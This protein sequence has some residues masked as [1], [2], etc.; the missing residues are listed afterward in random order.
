MVSTPVTT[1]QPSA[2]VKILLNERSQTTHS[3]FI[4]QNIR[5]FLPRL[6][7]LPGRTAPNS[8][9]FPQSEESAGQSFARYRC[10]GRDGASAVEPGIGE[11][12]IKSLPRRV[13]SHLR[14]QK[15]TQ[16]CFV[17]LR[18][19]NKRRGAPGDRGSARLSSGSR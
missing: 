1:P 10:Q 2:A 7:A 13:S 14:M 17:S 5:W 9:T 15:K 11:D 16:S 8:D 3:S 6:H 4:S 18:V 12:P 19:G